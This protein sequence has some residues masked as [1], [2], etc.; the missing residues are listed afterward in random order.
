[1][2]STMQ[3]TILITGSTDGIGL[4]TAKM[5]AAKNHH[6]L[7]HGRNPEKLENA[8]ESVTAAGGGGLVETF[9]ADLSDLHQVEQ[10][11]EDVMASHDTLDVLINNAG[12][13]RTANPVT[14]DG[15]DVRFVVNTL[16][17]V[18]LTRTLLATLSPC[19]R[20]INLSSAAQSP[21]NLEALSGLTRIPDAFDAYAQS[22]LAVTM[23]TRHF[24][25]SLDH[26]GP[27]IIAVNPGSMLGSKMVKEGFGVA[28]GDLEIGADILSRAALA[29]EF[30]SLSGKYYDNDSKRITDPH[31]DALDSTRRN[32]VV[33]QIEELLDRSS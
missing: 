25:E 21:V 30:G 1:M 15:L 2:D 6:I 11:A 23:W 26:T 16:A 31:P 9:E 10:L 20:V 22:K 18:L 5:L 14:R 27:V 19:G 12:I 29:D 33:S 24:A 13:F 3:K 4:A 8:R 28:G 32:E 7:L 17:P